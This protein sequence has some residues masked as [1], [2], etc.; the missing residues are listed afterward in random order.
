MS[1]AI[2]SPWYINTRRLSDI[3]RI[4]L[5]PHA[6]VAVTEGD[7]YRLDAM[8]AA[9][10]LAQRLVAGGKIPNIAKLISEGTF[11]G[12]A[13]CGV[14]ANAIFSGASGAAVRASESGKIVTKPRISVQIVVDGQACWF[15]GMLELDHFF[16]SSSVNLL[17]GKKQVYVVGKFEIDDGADRGLVQPWLIGDLLE[18]VDT[19]PLSVG[20]MADVYPGQI[21]AFN[22]MNEERSPSESRLKTV[23]LRITEAD[24]KSAFAELIGE[25]FIPKDWGGERS[26][27]Y[28]SRLTIDGT[29]TT[30]AFLLKGPAARGAMGYGTL[31]K[32]G[33][34]I[35][36]LFDEPAQL[37]VLQHHG[38]IETPVRKTMRQFAV[39]PV[40]PRRYCIIDGADTYRILRAYD[41]IDK[42]GTFRGK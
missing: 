36:R 41:Y 38:K 1:N 13:V 29:Q 40:N 10:L 17:S 20:H 5:S 16:S 4:P 24:V 33:D 28:T 19:L 14:W 11:T 15:D 9:K 23:M 42:D 12:G 37:L 27:L 8:Q 25:P 18:P 30:A 7:I 21:D 3:T 35:V 2:F 39:D 32:Q 6:Q 22:K 34:Q 31:G 26:D